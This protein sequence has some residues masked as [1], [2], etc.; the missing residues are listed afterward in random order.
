MFSAT[1]EKISNLFELKTN[2]SSVMVVYQVDKNTWRG[3]VVPYDIT[4]EADDKDTVI[5][6][7]REM[8]DS[9]VDGLKT[10]NNPN[11]L[12]IV[13]LSDESDQN[14]FNEIQ[15]NLFFDK[16]FKGVSKVDTEDYYAEAKSPT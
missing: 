5:S 12:S 1:K 4:F 6:V 14:K 11:H 7:L 16:L 9:Y 3:F 2:F 8:T 15:Q 10:Y 13:P